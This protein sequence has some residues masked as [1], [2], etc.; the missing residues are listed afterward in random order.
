MS[1]Y[2]CLTNTCIELKIIIFSSEM[3]EWKWKYYVAGNRNTKVKYTYLK[4]RTWKNWK[5]YLV[6]LWVCSFLNLFRQLGA[7]GRNKPAEWT[8]QRNIC[9]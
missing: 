8:S 2:I 7:P 6:K 4:T 9:E 1:E 5:I 3:F